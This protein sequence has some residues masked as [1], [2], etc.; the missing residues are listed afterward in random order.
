[1]ITGFRQIKMPWATSRI[2]KTTK[3]RWILDKYTK[4]NLLKMLSHRDL[5]NLADKIHERVAFDLL[6]K[7]YNTDEENNDGTNT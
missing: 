2:P 3:L 6:A 4:P 1:M 5:I 7:M